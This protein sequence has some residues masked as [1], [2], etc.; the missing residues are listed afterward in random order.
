M[1][2]HAFPQYAGLLRKI[3][4]E[5][6][7]Q[8]SDNSISRIEIVEQFQRQA[9]EEIPGV[10]PKFDKE[11]MRGRWPPAFGRYD[12]SLIRVW[13]AL[14]MSRLES[15]AQSGRESPVFSAPLTFVSDPKL[16]EILEADLGELRRADAAGCLK[17]TIIL[18]GAAIE[19]LLVDALA[20]H[21]ANQPNAPSHSTLLAWGLA[22]LIDKAIEYNLV[23]PAAGKFS[24]SVREY[25]NLVHPGRVVREGLTIDA[26]EARIAIEILNIVCRDLSVL[27]QGAGTP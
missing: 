1:N 4:D 16:R 7:Q 21:T 11:A 17:A 24:H 27:A 18:C 2:A 20:H 25:R 8:A 13:I 15:P 3:R 22:K 5:M 10:L 19:A 26:E 12:L 6:E 23:R 14:A 9:E